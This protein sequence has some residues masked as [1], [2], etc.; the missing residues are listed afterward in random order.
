MATTVFVVRF[1]VST[2]QK[3]RKRRWL[4]HTPHL[5]WWWFVFSWSVQRAYCRE[6]EKEEASETLPR[7]EP[8]GSD[9]IWYQCR[10]P[11]EQR[12]RTENEGVERTL[13][14]LFHWETDKPIHGSQQ[15]TWEKENEKARTAQRE[16][17][18]EWPIRR[19]LMWSR[20]EKRRPSQAML[21]WKRAAN[22]EEDRGWL[23]A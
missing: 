6:Q 2:H 1:E 14:L 13:D 10:K 3:K 17:W 8:E 16:R 21:N 15:T 5:S 11:E 9:P 7:C 12:S 22:Q 20:I 23:R 18:S 19:K 4:F